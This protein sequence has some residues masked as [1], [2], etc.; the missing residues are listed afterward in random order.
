MFPAIFKISVATDLKNNNNKITI[1]KKRTVLVRQNFLTW[2]ENFL[3][4]WGD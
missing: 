2:Q 3:K 4:I 1:K